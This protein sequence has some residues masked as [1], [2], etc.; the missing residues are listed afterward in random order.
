MSTESQTK[1]QAAGDTTQFGQHAH[2]WW[3]S[4][5]PLRTLHA[6][7]PA[8][9]E[10]IDERCRLAGKRV[11]DLG[12]GG[13]LLCEAMAARGAH[14]TGA[15]VASELIDIGRDHARQQ[16]LNI[17]YIHGSSGDLLIAGEDCFDIIVCLEMLE[18]VD[19]PGTIISDC[20]RLL[21]SGGDLV[22]STLNRTLTAYLLAV[23]GAEYITG[24][25]PR[26]T[27]DY[28][29]FIQPAELAACCRQNGLEVCDIS[30]L[31]YLPGLNKACISQSTAIN[32]LLHA[33]R[34]P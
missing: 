30:G 9:L 1:N 33:R 14:V 25:V 26:G 27:H 13:G 12:C 28:E 32:Y 2:S 22:L 19:D 11:L 24:L 31:T 10:Y 17:D 21:K 34:S 7:N 6:I 4:N 23:V 16:S 18:H 8:R 29:L 20:A 5:G 15:D 3:D